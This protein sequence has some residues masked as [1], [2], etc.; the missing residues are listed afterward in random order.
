MNS[1]NKGEAP[2]LAQWFRKKSSKFIISPRVFCVLMRSKIL[3]YKKENKDLIRTIVITED[4]ETKLL[5]EN[6]SLQLTIIPKDQ[7]PITLLADERE[8]ILNLTHNIRN[9]TMISHGLSLSDFDIKQTLARGLYGKILLA[10]KK[11]TGELFAIKEIKKNNLVKS[12]KI[13][14]LFLERKI[15]MKVRHPFIVSTICAFQD[16]SKV[17]FVLE[18]APGG[19]LLYQLNQREKLPK[20]DV[21]LYVAELAMALN[22][23]H[24]NKIIYRDL[25]PENILLDAQGYVK[26]TDFG[27]AK[28]LNTQNSTNT[29]CG[30][31]EYIAPEILSKKPYGT[32]I[33]WWALGILTYEL[34]FG[35]TP[36]K[37]ANRA[38]LF[39]LIKNENPTFPP[40]ADAD[41]KD[42][43]MMLLR[44]NPEQRGRFQDIIKHP[45]FNNLNFEDLYHKKVQPE[46][47]PSRNSPATSNEEPFEYDEALINSFTSPVDPIINEQFKGFSCYGIEEEEDSSS[48][49]EVES[50]SDENN[51]NIKPSTLSDLGPI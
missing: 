2:I 12:S 25:Q 37:T 33:D 49:V 5:N 47:V 13:Q 1:P 20:N 18:Y 7:K 29:F 10:Q 44:K 28:I 32:E 42:F 51:S 6:Q 48:D 24:N 41:T 40:D 30:T 16:D 38:T 22:Y 4:L 11:S 23:L 17:Y 39:N 31:S 46:F 21:I 14:C 3:I 34:L 35:K 50:S 9:L 8:P 36:F 27:L 26:L 15:L 43:I 19:S 45:F